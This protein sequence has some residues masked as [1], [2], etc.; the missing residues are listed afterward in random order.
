MQT[1][2]PMTAMRKKIAE[3]MAFSVHTAAPVT[4]TTEVDATEFV[5]AERY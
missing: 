4:L 2:L 5:V 1:R 3:H